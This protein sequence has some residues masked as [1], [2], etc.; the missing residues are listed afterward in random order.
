MSFE[1]KGGLR[2]GVNMMNKLKILL[3]E[4]FH[5]EP[6]I[7]YSVIRTGFY[8]ALVCPGEKREQYGITDGLIR[9]EHRHGKCA[10]YSERPGAGT[11]LGVRIWI[12]PLTFTICHSPLN[13]G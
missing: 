3:P 12:R 6:V 11:Q 8:D 9:Y 5:W 7:L 2:A 4:L 13:A 1:L 10:G